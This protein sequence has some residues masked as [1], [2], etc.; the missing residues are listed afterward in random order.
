MELVLHTGRLLT[1]SSPS[2]PRVELLWRSEIEADQLTDVELELLGPILPELVAELM[3][4]QDW[5]G[6]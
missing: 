2:E 6:E 3:I 5:T 4:I 1:S